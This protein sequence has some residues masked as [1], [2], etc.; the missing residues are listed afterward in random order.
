MARSGLSADELDQVAKSA[1]ERSAA[2][3]AAQADW[4]PYVDSPDWMRLPLRGYPDFS[5]WQP[6]LDE[7]IGHPAPDAFRARHNFRADDRDS[8]LSRRRP[9]S[10]SS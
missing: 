5:V 10:T 9:G 7:I 8:R 2:L 6:Y 4:P 1:A 3:A